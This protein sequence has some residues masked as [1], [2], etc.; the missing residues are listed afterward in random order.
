MY[1]III[2]IIYVKIKSQSELVYSCV[3]YYIG[4]YI[5]YS[6]ILSCV[7]AFLYTYCEDTPMLTAVF[8]FK[9][10]TSKIYS[11]ISL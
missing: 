3:H 8:K 9:T 1:I 6:Y 7:H 10:R 5:F 11:S 2:F 4:T